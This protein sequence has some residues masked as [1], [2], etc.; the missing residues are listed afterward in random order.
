MFTD[1]D[2]KQNTEHIDVKLASRM[3]NTKHSIKI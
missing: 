2:N 1:T 3:R